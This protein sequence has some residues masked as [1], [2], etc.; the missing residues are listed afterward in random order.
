MKKL[1]EVVE[2]LFKPGDKVGCIWDDQPHVLQDYSGMRSEY[3]VQLYSEKD[4][5]YIQFL[6]DGRCSKQQHYP[7]IWH[8]ETGSPPQPGE[9]PKWKPEKPTW[10]MCWNDLDDG[11]KLRLVVGFDDRWRHPYTTVTETHCVQYK[12]AEPCD[13]PEWWPEEWK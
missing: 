2:P 4:G 10:C 8:W 7:C 1:K 5:F 9:R 12:Y 11:K 3:S 6:P 13:P